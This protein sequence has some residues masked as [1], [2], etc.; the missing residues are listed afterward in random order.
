MF[1]DLTPN[2]PEERLRTLVEPFSQML[3][4]RRFFMEALR[5]V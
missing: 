5:V 4:E 1:Y 3:L 2:M